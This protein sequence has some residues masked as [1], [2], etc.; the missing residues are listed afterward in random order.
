MPARA[1][2]P[3]R[4]PRAALAA[5]LLLCACADDLTAETPAELNKSELSGGGVGRAQAGDGQRGGYE[6][7]SALLPS[8]C[9]AYPV[10]AR[11]ALT[12]GACAAPCAQGGCDIAL[13][14]VGAA[15]R[16]LALSARVTLAPSGEVALVWLDRDA[17]GARALAPD[18]LGALTLLS[19]ARALAG[20][21]GARGLLAP[22]PLGCEPPGAALL[23]ER[24]ELVGLAAGACGEFVLLPPLRPFVDEALRAG[25]APAPVPAP[26]PAPAP[27]PSPSPSPED[28]MG[29]SRQEALEQEERAAVGRAGGCFVSGERVCDGDVELT[30]NGVSYDGFHCGLVGWR[31]EPAGSFGAGCV[32]VE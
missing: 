9:L 14:A 11:A 27:S 24:D 26:A 31:C 10:S 29:A 7:V 20:L 1:P 19:E 16:L 18:A 2:R 5:A 22:S 13:M 23:N 15:P 3:P 21:D 4:R 17:G 25:P 30:C 28:H 12:T 32:P 6:L 8:G